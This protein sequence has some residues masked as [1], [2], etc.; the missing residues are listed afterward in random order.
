MKNL[1]NINRIEKDLNR[2]HSFK[3]S[4]FQI[5]NIIYSLVCLYRVVDCIKNI[6]RYTAKLGTFSF[7]SR[8]LLNKHLFQHF[9]IAKYWNGFFFADELNLS[10]F[11]R[12]YIWCTSIP[13]YLLYIL[14]RKSSTVFGFL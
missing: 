8:Y 6:P 9:S 7:F 12:V 10:I 5:K 1:Q 4:L 2:K 14:S 13:I 11:L 3:K